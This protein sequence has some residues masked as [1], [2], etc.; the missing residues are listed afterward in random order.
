[1]RV[2]L[3]PMEGVLD[4]YIRERL[5]IYDLCV[6]EFVRVLYTLLLPKAFYRLCPELHNGGRTKSSTPVR[7]QLLGNSPQWMVEN[8]A[9]TVE[10]GSHGIVLNGGCPTKQ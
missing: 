9:R 4:A 10:M 8:A 3:A 7:V 2:M 1:M 5:L 6:T